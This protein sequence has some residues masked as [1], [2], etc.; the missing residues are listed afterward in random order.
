M[1]KLHVSS[2]GMRGF[3]SLSFW[4]KVLGGNSGLLDVAWVFCY[5]S[6]FVWTMGKVAKLS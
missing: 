5:G 2:F 6:G 3:L 4:K 1:E